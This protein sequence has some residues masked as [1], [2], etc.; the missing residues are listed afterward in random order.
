MAKALVI[1][2]VWLG[3][4]AST[5]HA[6][7]LTVKSTLEENVEI[8]DNRQMQVNPLGPSYNTISSLYYSALARMPTSKFELNGDVKY[9]TFAGPGEENSKN[10]LDRFINGKFEHRQL[11]TTYNV[12]ASYW[13]ADAG[14][15]QLEETGI[16][17]RSGATIVKTVGGGLVH[18]LSPRDSIDWQTTYAETTF[19]DPGNPPVDSL[20]SVF[21]WIHTVNPIASVTPS[22][23]YQHLSY[24]DA[25]QSE[26]DFWK[27]TVGSRTRLTPR[28][29]LVTDGGIALLNSKNNGGGTSLVNL[30]S[31]SA[32]DWLGEM[33]L[34]YRLKT[35]EFT[36]YASHS[37]APT[38]F[39][40][41]LTKDTIGLSV[42]YQ[43]NTVSRLG[44]NIQFIHQTSVSGSNPID[45][46]DASLTYY[47]TLAREWRSRVSYRFSQNNSSAGIARSNTILFA[48]TRDVTI[49]P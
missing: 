47:R 45:R 16:I 23:Q 41:F 13:F 24:G 21:K 3:L 4:L 38:T 31:G 19:T 17:T 14:S 46:F 5:A 28:L 1:A 40:Q 2:S 7:D 35:I 42:D 12:F 26:V 39:G 18:R 25:A 32:I 6:I 22:I 11:L 9:R 33:S 44:S 48:L 27:A 43:V 8:S 37:T 20:T 10:A 15:V 36:L 29:T 49:L 34:I 30:P